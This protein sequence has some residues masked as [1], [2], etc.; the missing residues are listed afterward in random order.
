LK[1]FKTH[2]H[3]FTAFKKALTKDYGLSEEEMFFLSLYMQ[4]GTLPLPGTTDRLPAFFQKCPSYVL[5]PKANSYR[6]LNALP[7][8]LTG[9]SLGDRTPY[10]RERLHEVFGATSQKMLLRDCFN[11][12]FRGLEAEVLPRV[13]ERMRAHLLVSKEEYLT[14]QK[15]STNE[16]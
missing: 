4:A 8:D 16:K 14:E 2:A 3:G 1:M 10:D 7:T 11:A 5:S 12:T 9:G 15:G 13:I 6:F